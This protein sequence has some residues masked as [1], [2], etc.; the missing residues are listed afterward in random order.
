MKYLA[1]LA[2]LLLVCTL[3]LLPVGAQVNQESHNP[4]AQIVGGPE[5]SS[6]SK[7]P[8]KS[9]TSGLDRADQ[10]FLKNA[11]QGGRA[12]V[13]L[14]QLAV[15]KAADPKVKEFG[16]RMIGD[17]TKANDDLKSLATAKGLTLPSDLSA[18]D[19]AAKASLSKLSG[20][21]FDSA[22][23]R[24][25]VKDHKHD[26]AEFRKE[27][28]DAYDP[29]VKTFAGQ[30]LPTLESHLQQAQSIEGSLGKSHGK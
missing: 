25:M 30:Y 16:Q 18:P 29:D 12:E 20:S 24:L 23:M 22:Y 2:L 14:G 19:R 11:A 8:P 4:D 27:A 21:Q 17:H 15:Q 1:R 13:E 9:Q 6:T 3:V 5:H 7:K 10:Q 26:V 28:Y